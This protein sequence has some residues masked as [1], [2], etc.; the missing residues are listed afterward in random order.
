[1]L[2]NLLPLFNSSGHFIIHLANATIGAYS[3]QLN[4]AAPITVPVTLFSNSQVVS[5]LYSYA[6]RDNS[7]SSTILVNQYVTV[8][9][10]ARNIHNQTID[11]FT[12]SALLIAQCRVYLTASNGSLVHMAFGG[13][14][15][16]PS[17]GLKYYN[18]TT[19]APIRSNG[20]YF[21]NIY[22]QNVD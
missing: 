3:L 6:I 18:F 22:L 1:M 11:Q 7:T 21:S 12:D 16:D 4:L 20:K 17:T 9:V 2:S 5:P 14:F 8:K 10:F 19:I 15:P 13:T